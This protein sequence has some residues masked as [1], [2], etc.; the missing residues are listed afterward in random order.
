MAVATGVVAAGLALNPI[1][2]AIA[3]LYQVAGSINDFVDDHIEKLKRS[4]NE[5]IACSGRV[6]EGA[7]F[8]FGLGYITPIAI[9]AI[10]QLVLGNPLAAMATVATG[11]TLTNPIAMTCAAI[12]AIYYGWSA[13][14]DSER[15]AILDRLAS[16]L[17][18]GVE[19]LRALVE[20]VIRTTKDALSSKQLLAFKE[21]ISTQAVQFGRSLFDVTHKVGDLVAETA[22]AVG[23]FAKVTYDKAGV[24][25]GGAVDATTPALKG[26]YESVSEGVAS[27][28]SA[29][30]DAAGRA[31][32]AASE[33]AR[34][35]RDAA[36]GA[37]NDPRLPFPA[38][39]TVPWKPAPKTLVTEK[40]LA[41]KAPAKKVAVKK[42]VTA[43]AVRC[44]A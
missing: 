12:G 38:M 27:A 19:L 8:G 24:L 25:V 33:A 40:V 17:E 32:A 10:G 7:K 15:S 20:F 35:T 26:A 44:K 3:A 11:A 6:L 36:K 29:A 28:A 23:G 1:V 2:Q 18:M 39:T 43:M 42:P 16:G 30:K 5:T 37:I 34:A 31:G 41:K 14:N 21:Y 13:L 9:I 4:A 22:N